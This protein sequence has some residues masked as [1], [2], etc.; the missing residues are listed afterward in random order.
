[1]GAPPLM[2]FVYVHAIT[3][4][5]FGGFCSLWLCSAKC[6]G[7]REIFYRM[8]VPHSNA[9]SKELLIGLPM[10]NSRWSE[11]VPVNAI[12][13]P[14]QWTILTE[15]RVFQ[16]TRFPIRGLLWGIY[17]YM[18]TYFIPLFLH[19]FIEDRLRLSTKVLP[20][21]PVIGGYTHLR[22]HWHLGLRVN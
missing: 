2:F 6:N 5:R 22:F 19:Y 11:G 20:C 21:Q 16:Q 1:M 18:C 4:L 14:S 8:T 12:S 15:V 13:K 9:I 3:H 10:N 7:Q 17:C